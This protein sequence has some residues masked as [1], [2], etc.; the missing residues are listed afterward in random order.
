MKPARAVALALIAVAAIGLGYLRFAPDGA[1]VSLSAGAQPG[2]LNL[3]PS[4]YTTESG[5]YPADIGT[6]VVP[7]NRANPQSRLIALRLIRL[8]ARSI[9]STEP[10]FVLQGGPGFSNMNFP[11][12]SRYAEDRDVVLVGYRGIDSS[13]RLDCPEVKFALEHSPDFLSEQSFQAY[14][15][16]FR[17]CASRLTADGVDLAGYSL[18]QRIDDI[19]AAR[20]ALGYGQIN[21]LS[22]SAGTR[23]AMIYAWRYPDSIHRSVMIG[24]NPP[25]NFLVEA[26]PT[27]E[28]IG[29]YTR[30][31]ANSPSCAGRSKDLGALIAGTAGHM[32]DRW[33]FLPIK[34]GN[35]LVGTYFG[36]GDSRADGGLESA[37]TMLDTWLSTAEGDASGFW[38]SSLLGDV[39]LPKLFVWGEYGATGILDAPW[40]DG[41]YATRGESDSVLARAATDY[42]WGGGR[43][44]TAWPRSPDNAE[45][46]QVRMSNVEALLVG[47]ELDVATPPQI[48]RNQ[49][50]PYLP[51]GREVVLA[52]FG[53][54]PTFWHEQPQ[55]TTHLIDTFFASGQVDASLVKPVVVDF[56][57]QTTLT[58]LAKRIVVA[59]IGIALVAMLSLVWLVLHVRRR[60]AF[61]RASGVLLRSVYAVV[62]GIGA[63]FA[64]ALIALTALPGAATDDQLLVVLST[65]LPIGVAIY[66]ASVQREWS[67]QTRTVGFAAAL[68]GALVGGW[69]GFNTTLVPVALGTAVVGAVTAANLLLILLE[70]FRE[71]PFGHHL[72]RFA[73]AN[74]KTPPEVVPTGS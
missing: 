23:A 68:G 64:G 31:C 50:L 12:A 71:W 43:L 56:T 54:L 10:V 51:N 21:L 15:D 18:P 33:L 72:D 11:Q 53:H 36:F 44:A 5:S 59:M 63:W 4:S 48:A 22:D 2:D 14:G 35:V 62:L 30:L 9:P 65:S 60:G 47:G 55:A 20:V 1:S 19:E 38:F 3:E 58:M 46:T 61:G 25:G 17:S 41:Y 74:P 26:Q 49:L 7:E 8:R 39:M 66:F 57:P 16:G 32:P 52:G 34:P 27:E 67:P 6:F 73:A 45:Y 70:I 29:R 37:P 69:L 28:Q 40:A 42:I 13:T 24:V